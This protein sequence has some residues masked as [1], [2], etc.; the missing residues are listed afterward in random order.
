M[1]EIMTVRKIMVN[2]AVCMPSFKPAN[3]AQTAPIKPQKAAADRSKRGTE[4]R[5]LTPFRAPCR[6]VGDHFCGCEFP[7]GGVVPKTSIASNIRAT[8]TESL[9]EG[10]VRLCPENQITDP[11]QGSVSGEL[12]QLRSV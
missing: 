10:K 7:G 8:A 6:V 11:A 4:Y 3:S 1:A 5:T 12:L 9:I 2:G